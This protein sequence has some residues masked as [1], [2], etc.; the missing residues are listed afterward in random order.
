ME[1]VELGWNS[2]LSTFEP[3]TIEG[4]IFSIVGSSR[5][6]RSPYG[7]DHVDERVYQLFLQKRPVKSESGC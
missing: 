3:A 6:N 7:A 2:V 1:L 5:A 4:A